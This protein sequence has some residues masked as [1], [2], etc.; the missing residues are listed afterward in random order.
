MNT[1]ALRVQARWAA[2][3]LEPLQV[4]L[5]R[6][7]VTSLFQGQPAAQV[8]ASVPLFYSLCSQAQGLAAG[9]ALAA[10]RGEAH[11]TPSPAST[12]AL[13]LEALHEHLWRLLLDWPVAL[14]LEAPREAFAIWRK[15][16]QADPASFAAATRQLFERALGLDPGTGQPR[17]EGLAARCLSQ[18]QHPLTLP[19]R[20]DD[21]LPDPAPWLADDQDPA[22]G[23]SGLE[24]AAA[25]GA[26][27][28]HIATPPGPGLAYARRLLQ[29]LEAWQALG[30][31]QPYPLR[32][33]ARPD[34]RLGLGLTRT[35]RGLL[36]HE[37]LLEAGDRVGCYRIWAPTDRLFAD[38]APLTRL[39]QALAP[40]DAGAT[41]R[42][43]ELAILALDP[44]VPY[45]IDWTE[46]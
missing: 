28:R 19:A 12:R 29:A 15:C 30:T 17:P 38:A 3:R 41:R 25:D 21:A 36:L 22:A 23:M 16:R 32:S 34:R 4:E 27:S 44:C 11:W 6:P 18:L 1:G 2:G 24:T 14:G 40:E 42:A 13:W 39:L 8:Q 43:L 37:A 31:E 45:G 9:A 26:N 10:A 7:A 20:D 33:A 35:A 46:N 5:Q